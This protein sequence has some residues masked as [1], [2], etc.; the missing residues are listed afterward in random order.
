MHIEGKLSVLKNMA[1]EYGVEKIANYILDNPKFQI[2]SGSSH[3]TQHHYGK[4]GLFNHTYEV[5]HLCKMM[6]KYYSCYSIDSKVLFLG[7]LYH[8]CGKV[9]DYKPLND[10]LTSWDS[11][12]HKRL[13][14]HISKSSIEWS[15]ACCNNWEELALIESKFS[16]YSNI[17]EKQFNSFFDSVAHIILSHHGNRIAGSP[18]SPKSREAWLVHL[19][20][21]ISARMYDADTWDVVTGKNTGD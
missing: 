18:V 1:V 16:D 9:Y 14:H 20:D 12:N 5:I 17:S 6:S 10:E 3:I 4:H 2:W 8:D 7:A 15:F 21:G 11:E 13:I 19:C